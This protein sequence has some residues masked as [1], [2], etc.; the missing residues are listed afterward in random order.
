[1]AT[2]TV[3]LYNKFGHCKFKNLCRSRHVNTLC[4]T[5]NCNVKIC[6]FR[7]PKMCR[8]FRDYGLCRFNPCS[9]QHDILLTASVKEMKDKLEKKDEEIVEL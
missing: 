2:A 9:Y 5:K 3:C 4:E 8:F 1:M 6:E 7:H